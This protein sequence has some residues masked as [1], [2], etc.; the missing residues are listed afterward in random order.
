MANLSAGVDHGCMD[1]ER[2]AARR[3][4]VILSAQFDADVKHELDEL[5]ELNHRSTSAELR[6]AVDR[7]LRLEG[8]QPRVAAGVAA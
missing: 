7:H 5:A 4:R 1:D 3:R 6:V 8:R 2:A